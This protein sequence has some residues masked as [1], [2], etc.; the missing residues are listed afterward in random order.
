M[1]RPCPKKACCV[2]VLVLLASGAIGRLS[3]VGTALGAET[4]AAPLA[5]DVTNASEAESCA[6]KDNV[7]VTFASPRLRRFRIE[8]AH[9]AY[10]GAVKGDG[11]TRE[12]DWTD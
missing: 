11:E 4:R 12:P 8:A 5:V 6:E 10:I 9:P 2:L 7:T 1:I 3:A